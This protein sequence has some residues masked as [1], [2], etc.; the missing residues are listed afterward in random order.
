MDPLPRNGPYYT[1]RLLG[2]PVVFHWTFPAAGFGIGL[3]FSSLVFYSTSLAPALQAFLWTTAACVVLIIAHEAGHAL[4]ARLLSLEVTA[5]VIAH[6]GGRCFISAQPSPITDL[7]F[8]AAGVLAQFA[9]MVFTVS[10]L[11]IFGA[12]SSLP[13]KCVVFVLTAGNAILM[14]ANLV[15]YQGND[16]ARIVNAICAL[17]RRKPG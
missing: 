11:W 7:F 17:W 16:G 13:L 10:L 6:V 5:I 4:A 1:L 8:S 3:I 12:P 15:P 9:V 2:L 14:I